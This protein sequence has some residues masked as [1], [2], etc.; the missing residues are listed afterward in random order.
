[1]RTPTSPRRPAYRLAPALLIATLALLSL[2][3]TTISSAEPQ[4]ASYQVFLPLLRGGSGQTPPPPP[5]P[6]PTTEG[7]VS[8]LRDVASN[9][10]SAAVD[11]AGGM[12]L[13]FTAWHNPGGGSFYAY[14]PGADPAACDS[15]SAWSVVNLPVEAALAQLR[16]DPQGHPRILLQTSTGAGRFIYGA[17]D[18]GCTSVTG[19]KFAEAALT[20]NASTGADTRLS[21]F[22]LDREGHPRFFYVDYANDSNEH[23]GTWYAFCDT[24][25]ADGQGWSAVRLSSQDWKYVD[26]ELTAD[27]LPRALALDPTGEQIQY[28]SCEG[29]CG[30]AA[31][32]RNTPLFGRGSGP[33]A[34]WSL[35]L[36]GQGRPRIAVYTGVY[37]GEYAD[38]GHRL[39]YAWCDE[40]C[41]SPERWGQRRVG[42]PQGVGAGADLQLDSAGRPRIAYQD[43]GANAAGIGY[44]WCDSACEQPETAWRFA[45][46]ESAD[47]L[48]ADYPQSLF[49]NCTAGTWAGFRPMLSLDA[50]GNPRVAYDGEHQQRC[51]YQ[52]PG[53]QPYE[54][55]DT[56]WRTARLVFFPQLR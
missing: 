25:C 40:G 5:P 15:E 9:S 41:A 45:V 14:C 29:A 46:A 4:A 28:L 33:D 53:Q 54:R 47:T 42:L 17:C 13:A 24:G 11:A 18:G 50:R 22:A 2:G 12:H 16:L 8:L 48:N 44:G 23:I 26:L 52:E 27:G 35:A 56:R 20:K 10:V 1:M 39:F 43:G 51:L 21:A 31:S 32:W 6:P 34:S 7:N 19:W 30:Q 38:A 37:E 36:D 49:P 3:L 55:V